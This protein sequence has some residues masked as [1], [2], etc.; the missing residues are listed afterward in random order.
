MGFDPKCH[1]NGS[2][3]NR[4]WKEQLKTA[5]TDGL[6][7][8][9]DTG[10]PSFPDQ[11]QT[12]AP[13]NPHKGRRLGLMSS[14]RSR[15]ATSSQRPSLNGPFTGSDVSVGPAGIRTVILRKSSIYR[16][17]PRPSGAAL[18]LTAL[19]SARSR[20]CIY[21]TTERTQVTFVIPGAQ[22]GA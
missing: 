14:T 7:P 16:Q 21:T 11:T 13:K 5:Q 12:L 17:Q 3:A 15:L 19:A 9:N 10:T 1:V 18:A 8:S 6:G 20:Q 2:G 22:S 4:R